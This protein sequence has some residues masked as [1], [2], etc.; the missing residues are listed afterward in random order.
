MKERTGSEHLGFRG[1]IWIAL[2]V[3]AVAVGA[4]ASAALAIER[5][6]IRPTI[7]GNAKFKSLEIEDL[8][9]GCFRANEVIVNEA[10]HLP[11]NG[12]HAGSA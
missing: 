8:T 5:L 4:S 1:L 11:E 12:L 7:V 2:E 3:G 6:A 10:R 9:V